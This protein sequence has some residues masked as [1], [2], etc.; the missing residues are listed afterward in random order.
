LR[1]GIS[2]IALHSITIWPVQF[3]RITGKKLWKRD[4]QRVITLIFFARQRAHDG[5]G[6]FVPA[7]LRGINVNPKDSKA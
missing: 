5:V 1:A 3:I 2:L 4:K 7:T 6:R